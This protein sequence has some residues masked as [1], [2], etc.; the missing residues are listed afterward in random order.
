MDPHRHEP[1]AVDVAR[2]DTAL[3]MIAYRVRERRPAPGSAAGDAANDLGA[4]RVALVVQRSTLELAQRMVVDLS[5]D[6]ARHIAPHLTNDL[7]VDAT[8]PAL[9]A[10]LDCGV[11]VGRRHA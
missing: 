2:H 4:P 10:G 9:D 7:V 11:E 8:A 5:R 1:F 6:V 3:E